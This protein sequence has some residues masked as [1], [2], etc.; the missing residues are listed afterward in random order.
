MRSYKRASGAGVLLGLDSP[1]VVT[2]RLR[3]VANGP[4]DNDGYQTSPSVARLGSVDASAVRAADRQ[5]LV[6]L[7][8]AVAENAHDLLADAELLLGAGRSARAYSLALLAAE[9][10]AKAYVVLTLSFMPAELRA[11]M[12][13]K[14]FRDF[15]EDHKLKMA[16]A[17]LLTALD[18]ADPGVAGRV[19]AMPDLDGV[20]TTAV[21]QAGDANVAKQRG[22]YV[23]LLAGGMLSLPS[24]VTEGKAAEAVA[25][26]REV[27]AAAALL[28]DQDALAQ[29]ADPPAAAG[30]L[31]SA[32]F[33]RYL[34]VRSAGA[35]AVI[36]ELTDIANR[37]QDG[38]A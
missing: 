12:P 20:I 23:D 37:L 10:W 36:A 11:Q 17:W 34:D 5:L 3:E 21:Q 4:H 6:R 8:A 32:V 19:A 13:V 9:E 38:T 14:D 1:V 30:D 7:A 25:R 35:D 28:H 29:F 15:L 16:G 2:R 26:A 31:A 24:E 18:A 22:L 27:G 33:G